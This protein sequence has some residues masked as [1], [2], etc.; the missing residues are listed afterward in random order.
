[1]Q[2]A[3]RISFLALA[4]LA[5]GCLFTPAM[6]AATLLELSDEALVRDSELV[7]VGRCVNVASEWR[8]GGLFT[9]ATIEVSD[10]LKGDP[11]HSIRV[12]IPGGV[13]LDREVPVAVTWPDSPTIDPQEDVL[14]FLVPSLDGGGEYF[15][16]GF[17][18]GKLSLTV[19]EDGRVLATRN[20]ADIHLHGDHGVHLG[21]LYA[22]PLDHWRETIQRAVAEGR[23]GR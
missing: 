4:A 5:L 11:R 14:L 6:G 20:L 15:V 13:D 10:V 7:I 9:L 19:G 21:D 1:M 16:T 18:Q 23:S 22:V 17:S 12:L 3:A 8:K 2:L